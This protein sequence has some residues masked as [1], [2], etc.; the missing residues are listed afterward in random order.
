MIA[1]FERY[2]SL[3]L[4]CVQREYPSHVSLPM[5]GPED[6]R[7]PC[8]LFP[9]FYGCYDWHSAVHGHWLLARLT[10]LYPHAPFASDARAVL[11]TNITPANIE[12]ETDFFSKRPT[13]ERPYGL[14]WLLR[15]EAELRLGREPLAHELAAHLRPLAELALRRLHEWLPKLTYPV[16]SG[17]HNQTHDVETRRLVRDRTHYFYRDDTKYGLHLEPSGEDFLSPALGAADL[18]SR[19]LDEGELGEWLSQVFPGLLGGGAR[20]WLAPVMCSDRAD[21]KLAHLD[22]LNLS[23]AWM[24]D[25]IANAL[26]KGDLRVATLRSAADDHRTVGLAAVEGPHYAGTHWLGTFAVY[27]LTAGR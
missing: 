1:T 7:S 24:L 17:T 16:R 10:R 27:L 20:S 4:A 22:G 9:A 8:E 6:V 5:F 21:G 25:S 14:V 23:R 15:L 12:R 11:Q 2:A 3:A 26:R 19:L 13:F 18:M